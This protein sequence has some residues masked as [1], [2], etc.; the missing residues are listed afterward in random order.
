MWGLRAAMSK[1]SSF[2]VAQFDTLRL[3]LIKIAARVVEMKT[4]IRL[5]PPTSCPDQRTLRI[6]LSRAAT[7]DINNGA[8]TSQNKPAD[9][10]T[11]TPACHHAG[12]PPAPDE[13]RGKA[14]Q[15]RPHRRFRPPKPNPVH[16]AG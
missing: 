7:R 11:Q 5:H 9:L 1:R 10:N 15:W 3:R 12:S 4:Q 14:P 16:Q 6:V 2:A 13:A 8:Q